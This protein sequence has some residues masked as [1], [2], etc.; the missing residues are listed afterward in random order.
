MSDRKKTGT[1]SWDAGQVRR[2]T[3]RQ[4]AEKK[5]SK[6]KKSKLGVLYYILGVLVASALLA[7]IAW[8]M[9]NDVCAL[10]KEPLTA[11]VKVERGDSVGDVTNK[12]KK[13]GLI[14]SKLLFRVFAVIFDADEIISPGTYE[15]DTDMDF[16]CLIHSMVSSQ[17]VVPPN[18]VT[19]TIPEGYTVA[20][21]ISVLAENGVCSEEELTEAAKNHVFTEYDFVDNVNLGSITRLEGYLAPDTYEFFEDSAPEVALARLLDNFDYWMNDTVRADIIKSGYTMEEIVI[22][23][24]VIEKEAIGD[25]EER[26]NIASVFYNRIEN[27]SFET[28]GL[29]QSDATIYYV[30]RTQGLPDTAFSTSI[31]SPYNTY[32]H[33]GLPAGSICN[34]SRSALLA[35]V[36]PNDTNYYYFAY[37]TDNVS[38][39]FR[40]YAE[41]LKFINSPMYRPD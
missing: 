17:S 13:A 38:H 21:T 9:V 6:Q 16:R 8:L 32:L 26:K 15:L 24:S 27:P 35:A 36:Y 39:F 14:E 1:T 37:G 40:N 31:D 11:T 23:A 41:H 22:M 25:D 30:L 12:L 18:V 4:P 5:A 28:Y 19:V 29:L 33:P 3:G 34:P 10:N 7:G 20:Q 2:E